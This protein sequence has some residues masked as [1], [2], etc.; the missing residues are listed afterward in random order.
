VA[1]DFK[2]GD[3]FATDYRIARKLGQGGF[4]AVYEV[5]Q[6][7]TS[8]RRALKVLLPEVLAEHPGIAKR[9]DTEA[10]VGAQIDS[11]HV[12]EVI[13][14][15][16][17]PM[18]WLVMEL[19]DG[20]DL[21]KFAERTG[22]L[23]PGAVNEILGQVCHALA[24]AHRRG[25]VHR[26]LKPENIFL[27]RPRR[28]GAAVTV[29]ILDFGIARIVAEVKTKSS[30]TRGVLGSAFWLAPEQADHE[31][32]EVTPAA[33]VWALG[34]LAF[35]LLAGQMFWK[36][37]TNAAATMTMMVTEMF[38]AGMP[39]ASVRATELGVRARIPAGFDAWFA[40]CLQRDWRA[41]FADAGQAYAELDGI[42][43]P[44]EATPVPPPRPTPPPA[45]ILPVTQGS[46]TEVMPRPA[47]EAI[48]ESTPRIRTLPAAPPA[49]PRRVPWG[50]V[51]LAA[52]VV[53]LAGVGAAVWPKKEA[54]HDVADAGATAS[55]SAV[56]VPPPPVPPCPEGAVFV[57]GDTFTMGSADADADE[58]PPHPVKLSA[59]CLD[60]TEVTVAAYR[61][62]TKEP[63]N[64]V[65]CAAAPTTVLITGLSAEDTKFWST[66][67]NGDK[68]DKNTHPINCVDWTQA[69]AYCRWTGGALPTEAQWEYAARGTDGRKYP[70]GNDKP[71]AKLLNACGTECRAMGEKLGKKGWKVM[72]EE[73][74]G[75]GATS[76]VGAY[77][78][79]ASPFGALDMAGNVWEWV[80]DW[81]APYPASG[82]TTAEDPKGPDKSPESRRVIRGGGW[83]SGDASWVRA[84]LRSRDDVSNRVNSVGFRCARGP[85]F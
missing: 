62:C 78:P 25:I 76:P 63:R 57:K 11:D 68:A 52:A 51:G 84:A 24:D 7:S 44:P 29:K 77:L 48:E 41:R 55:A 32:N 54:P 12:V 64:G 6:I 20:E 39:V 49:V 3:V 35:R 42:L 43:S 81:Y 60:K 14:S 8:R 69:E 9:F 53:G 73:D 1:L 75:A 5:E 4:G 56:V 22:P 31:N 16:V 83:Y 58:K 50:A 79:G 15:G 45:P 2:P 70:W 17:D 71:G 80:A 47:A 34:L 10:K 72:Y 59:F 33:D 28:K 30:K 19:L 26:D 37:A 85:K 13:A 27:A 46:G 65:T 66:F 21:D 40:R 38:V 23:G 74:D 61:Q 18:P 67:C 82:D 36:T